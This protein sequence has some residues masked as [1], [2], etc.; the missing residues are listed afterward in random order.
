MRQHRSRQVRARPAASAH[1][2]HHHAHFDRTRAG[3]AVLLGYRQSDQAHGR[4]F[5]PHRRVEPVSVAISVR[6][7]ASRS[8]APSGRRPPAQ[9]ALFFAHRDGAP[10]A[11]AAAQPSEQGR[12][13]GWRTG[14]RRTTV[15]CR[16]SAPPRRSRGTLRAP[17]R[18]GTARRRGEPLGVVEVLVVEQVQ[19]ADADPGR[20]QSAQIGRAAPAPRPPGRPC[21]DRPPSRTGCCSRSTAGARDR[22]VLPRCGRRASGR[23]APA[24]SGSPRRGHAPAVPAPRPARRRHW[25][26]RSRSGRRSTAGRP[27]SHVSAV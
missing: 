5:A 16:L 17:R 27:A 1:L 22:R 25:P 8:V 4:Q 12:C 2:L 10:V 7:C 11:M 6:T 3:A 14:C 13:A 24:R 9:V 21:R 20:G 15:T 18:L 26:R 23:P 19:R